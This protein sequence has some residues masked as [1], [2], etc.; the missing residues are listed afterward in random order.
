MNSEPTSAVSSLATSRY[1]LLSM[2]DTLNTGLITGASCLC[3]SG[4]KGIVLLTSLWH[5]V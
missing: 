3:M 1:T 5:S 4:E 2:Q